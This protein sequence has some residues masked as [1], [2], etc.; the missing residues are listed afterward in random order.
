MFEGAT[1]VEADILS[2]SSLASTVFSKPVDVVI[3]C[4]ASRSGVK[5]DADRVDYQASL[6]TLNAGI[7]AAGKSGSLAQFILLSAFCVGKPRLEFQK[8]KLKMEA[9]LQAAQE[10][11]TLGRYS[12]V[13]PTAYFKSLSGQFEL[14]QKVRPN[15]GVLI[16]NFHLLFLSAAGVAIRYVWRRQHLQ[17]LRHRF[18]FIMIL[19]SNGVTHFSSC[20]AGATRSRRRTWRRTCWTAPPRATSGTRS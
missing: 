2:E 4:L 3:S 5:E 14:V 13:R 11:G 8:A 18:F 12:I 15:H 9:A 7:A 19:S 1:V 10:K 17:V 16:S 6:N 20:L